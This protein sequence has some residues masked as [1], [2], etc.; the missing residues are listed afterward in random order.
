[1]NYRRV[2]I[3]VLVSCFL[4]GMILFSGCSSH[5][6]DLEPVEKSSKRHRPIPG[7]KDVR[8]MCR[9]QIS[10]IRRTAREVRRVIYI[11]PDTVLCPSCKGKL[12]LFIKDGY[13]CVGELNV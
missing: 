5:P 11:S 10:E 2:V 6:D 3:S 7:P 9:P 12:Y 13:L 4:V 1:M 8:N